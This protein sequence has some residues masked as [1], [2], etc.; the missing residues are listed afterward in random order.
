M[1]L[2]YLLFGFMAGTMANFPFPNTYK[3]GPYTL[4]YIIGIASLLCIFSTT[5]LAAQTLFRE[6]E[7][8]FEE[9]LYAAP[10]RKIP[11]V[12]SRFT[13]ILC[14]S[15]LCYF[16]L[17]G[18]LMAGHLLQ[19]TNSEVFGPFRPMNYLQPFFVLLLPNI[20]FCTAVACSIG[21]FTKNKMLVY[22]SGVFIYFL[23]WGVAMF[24]NSPLIAN[25]TPLSDA[26]L[27]RSAIIDPFGMAAFLEQTRYWTAL[28]RN[29]QLLQLSGSLLLN[30]VI[31]LFI[32]FAL[33]FVA[34]T[35]F[36]FLTNTNRRK[37]KKMPETG[38]SSYSSY[39]TVST[40]TAALGYELQSL[41]SLI[42]MESRNILKGVPIWM[43]CIG[44]IGFLGIETF[45]N[46]SGN[47]RIPESYATTWLM[48]E[49]VLSELPLVALMVLLFYGTEVF[50]RSRDARFDA[51]ENTTALNPLVSQLSKWLSLIPIILL[52]L[53]AS[54]VTGVSIQF[55]KG[56]TIID[57][58]LYASLFYFI[59]LPVTLSAGLIICIQ[60]LVR[61]K[62]LAIAVSGI[63]VIL[64]NTSL[65]KIAGM[66]HPLLKFA[67]TFQGEY[68]EMNGF[69]RDVTAFH[70][71][72]IYWSCIT[73]ALFMLITKNRK[74]QP[75]RTLLSVKN[76][77][78]LL[79]LAGAGLT[80]G[81]IF[82][83]TRITGS[84]AIADWKQ[85]AE[86]AYAFLKNKPQPVVTAVKTTIDLY[87]GD[88]SYQVKGIYTLLNKTQAPIDTL[89]LYGDKE[90]NWRTWKLDG[91]ALV[92]AD[93]TYG[94]YVFAAD[95]PLKPGDSTKLQFGFSYTGSAFNAAAS[96]NTI[97]RNGSFIRISNYFPKPGY[98]SNNEIEDINERKKRQLPMVN[99]LLPLEAPREAEKD[100][101][102]FDA[103]ISTDQEQT[104]IS[105]GELKKQ[106]KK[107]QRN[108]FQYNNSTPIPFRFAVASAKYALQKTKHGKTNIEVY[109]HP[110]HYR[111]IDHLVS[112]AVQSLDYCEKH[113]GVYPF[114]TLRFT[115]IA[116]FTKGFAGT[117][118]PGS[119]FINEAFGYQNK[120]D[121][122]PG[123]DILT[124]LVSHE[125]SHT[126][127][128]NSK[129]S[130]GYREGSALLTETLAMYT[131]LMIYKERYGESHLADRVNVHKNIYLSE[132][133][134][135]GEEPLYKLHPGK[136]YLHYDKGMVMMYQLYR[137]LGEEKINTALQ[138][139]Y[140]KFSYPNA[141]PVSTDL[142]NEF[143][144]VSSPADRLKI[145]EL[146]KQVVTYDMVLDKAET[147]EAAGGAHRLA[148]NAVLYK[149]AE[150]GRGKS[151]SVPFQE[152]I[153]VA[154]YFD[155]DKYKTV[156][157]KPNASKIDTTLLFQ[158]KPV[159]V[160][161]DPDG[162]FL[163]RSEEKKEKRVDA[164]SK[165]QRRRTWSVT[166]A[167]I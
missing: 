2:F 161:L 88:E 116:A 144:S 93:T 50:W 9:T 120:L 27:Q 139:F 18:G 56:Y 159:K 34:Y 99:N 22:V 64:T 83:Q 103:T 7:A 58:K 42:R 86:N 44:W 74:R 155:K 81:Y 129:I 133:N 19:A 69:G 10:L 5:V 65:G 141:G 12:T 166:P 1:L 77:V 115:E 84:S 79:S 138:R 130:P 23:Y 121:N 11:Y 37:T 110:G 137:L 124:E 106:W 165:T 3:N 147:S 6:K 45:S 52:L 123:K 71:K 78:L 152:P 145:D 131:E 49:G 122:N 82:K 32:S 153:D 91:G 112:T 142:L 156:L 114:Q 140:T 134:A 104:V 157:L 39:Q 111:N 96:Y 98:N 61:N 68:S 13:I 118:Y 100:F 128:G 102:S 132:R 70:Y 38:K 127:W 160:V 80:G 149:Y 54:I 60:A 16:L 47:T 25:S 117:A 136:P 4:N 76:M 40:H 43:I 28:Q 55:L 95:K 66:R 14:V 20:L 85:A 164:E 109:Y 53:M 17:I 92:K 125:L 89:Y 36:R 163:N 167:F 41:W 94:Y 143:Y 108:Y 135:A 26:S 29:N 33:L 30:R 62:Y 73:I 59:G 154:V 75:G 119:L 57:W 162:R 105:V 46:I 101:I 51:F 113:F 63:V 8:N 150:D 21:L 87:P 148:I 126:W 31:Y 97:I 67:N 35:K 146:F 48:I 90:L 72:M 158:Q 24:T 107:D 151:V 15:A